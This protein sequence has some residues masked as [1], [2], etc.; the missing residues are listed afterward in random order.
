MDHQKILNL[1]NTH[2]ICVVDVGAADGLAKRWQSIA[3]LL[4]VIAFEP[5][6][7]STLCGDE[8]SLSEIIIVPKAAAAYEGIRKLFLTR[9]PRCSSLLRPNVAVIKRHPDAQRYDVIGETMVEC[10]TVD[11]VLKQHNFAMDFIK[12]DTQGTELEVLKGS[13]KSLKNCIGIEV[14]VEFQQ[15]YEGA[16][17]FREIDA[18]VNQIG[19]ELLDLRRTYFLRNV[20]NTTEQQKGQLIFGD[21]LYFRDWHT[22]EL[23]R[24][25]LLKQA[26]L[27]LTYGYADIVI[28]MTLNAKSF[29]VEDREILQIFCRNLSPLSVMVGQRKD[30]F[31]GTGYQLN[32]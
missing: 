10:T 21:A 18:H 20:N 5:D 14:E 25:K 29:S 28:D 11:N 3:S 32:I 16:S 9:K 15:L 23:D 4:K 2:S 22:F 30:T 6:A 27:L 19:F 31:I 7:R 26:I 17:V 1:L 24:E 12:I 8:K 13:E